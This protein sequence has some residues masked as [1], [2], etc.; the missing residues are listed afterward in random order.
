MSNKLS[1]RFDAHT[2]TR[3]S[4]AGLHRNVCIM[5]AMAT[6]RALLKMGINMYIPVEYLGRSVWVF[7]HPHMVCVIID[8]TQ[9]PQVK[10]VLQVMQCHAQEVKHTM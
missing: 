6:F 4:N 2:C 7:K 5:G 1:V 3:I 10:H 8:Y 9:F